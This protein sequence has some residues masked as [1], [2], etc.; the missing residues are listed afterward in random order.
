MGSVSSLG[1]GSGIL[2]NDLLDD[3]VSAQREP[4]VE[5]LDAE[6]KETEAKLSAFGQFRSAVSN[7][8]G[9]ADA[10]TDPTTLRSFKGESSNEAISVE[11][12]DSVAQKGS[13]SVNVNQVAQAQALASETYADRDSTEIGAGDLTF[14]VGDQSTTITLDESNNTLNGLASEINESDMGVNASILNTGDG[15]RMVL[16]ADQTGTAN[17]MEITTNDGSLDAF[18][19]ANLEET[20]AAKDAKVNI[21]GVEV[22]RSTN[23]IEGVIDGV[24]LN[25]SGETDLPADVNVSQDLEEPTAKVQELVD[26]FNQVKGTANELTSF[27]SEA[28]EGSILTGDSTIRSTMNQLSREFS[29]IVPGLENASVRSLADVGITTDFNTGQLQFDSAKFQEKLQSNPDDVTAL[30]AN[31]GRASD[32][33]V[34]FVRS[35]SSTQ[36]G[37]YDV[38]VDSIATRGSF[39]A[40][41]ALPDTLEVDGTNNT[42]SLRL[43]GGEEAQI[44]LTQGT[45]STQDELLTEI[46]NQVADNTT[47]QAGGDSLQ[48][49]LGPDNNKL[50]FTSSEYG[51]DSEVE[52]TQGNDALG[53]T[54]TGTG[55]AGTDVQGT[56]DGQQ[57]EGDGQVLF[58]G[59]DQGDASGIQVRVRGGET[60]ARGS[61]NYIEGVG[62][63]IAERISQLGSSN[64]ALS[65]R[66]ESFQNDLEGIQEDRQDLNERFTSLRERLSSQFASA[67]QRISQFQQTGNYLEQQLAGLT[68]G[69]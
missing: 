3:I 61:V 55:T 11:V 47:I 65:S 41:Q 4:A 26:A 31:Q 8:E 29:Q 33:Q 1:I 17:A 44:T 43:N 67:D 45:Y 19:T 59:R 18:T 24:T 49:G 9:P 69:N 35:T 2:T 53:I 6:Q 64:G 58:L 51:S 16:N 7:L 28:G 10:L 68:G 15:Y 21:S 63:S 30:F 57:A 20:R 37:E 50:Q 52:I 14:N 34:E 46:Q 42:F 27:D 25:I 48:V 40:G 62:N 56:I 23:T 39:T 22:T 36:P 13:Y 54:T 38:N 12:D 32:G 5:R 66:E 60:G